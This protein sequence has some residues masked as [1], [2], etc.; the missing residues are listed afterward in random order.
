LAL[1][2]LEQDYL[3]IKAENSGLRA[4]NKRLVSNNDWYRKEMERQA[5]LDTI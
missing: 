5:K 1:E 3:K 4:E 2:V